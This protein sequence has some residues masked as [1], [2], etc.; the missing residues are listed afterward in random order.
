MVY[1]NPQER[2]PRVA[3]E[4]LLYG[5]NWNI[6]E[7]IAGHMIQLPV[8]LKNYRGTASNESVGD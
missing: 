5:A 6:I 8:E 7:T 2:R 1:A 4:E 3:Q